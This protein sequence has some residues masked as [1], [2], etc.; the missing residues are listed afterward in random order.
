M[1]HAP[2]RAVARIDLGAIERNCGR[3]RALLGPGT[4]L[5][6]VVKADAY[7][8]GVAWCAK[9]ALA[10]GATWLAVATGGEA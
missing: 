8:H 5:C 4:E 1:T 3:L 2:E 7:G 10:G 6:A 9:A